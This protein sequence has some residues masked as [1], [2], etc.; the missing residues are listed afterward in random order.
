MA[1]NPNVPPPEPLI[2]LSTPPEPGEV[3]TTPMP[4][5]ILPSMPSITPWKGTVMK[6]MKP[7]REP[8]LSPSKYRNERPDNGTKNSKEFGPSSDAQKD[9]PHRHLNLARH[10]CLIT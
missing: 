3:Q 5:V 1:T 8:E 2:P 6:N 7:T 10:A 9:N 4:M